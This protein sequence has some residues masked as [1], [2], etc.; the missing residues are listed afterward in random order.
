MRATRRAELVTAVADAQRAVRL[1]G[2]AAALGV[3]ALAFDAVT[4]PHFIKVSWVL[5]AAMSVCG[6]V[7]L[8]L[9]T[10]RRPTPKAATIGFLIVNA[11]ILV[12]L[13]VGTELIAESGVRWVPFRQYQL[14]AMVVALL[15]PPK[16]W[17]GVVTISAYAGAAL[18]QL[19]LFDPSIREHLPY[20]DP[21]ATVVYGV[22]AIAVLAY[23]LRSTRIEREAVRAHAEAQDYA[24]LARAMVALR[25][26][27]NSPLQTISN[28]VELLR[29]EGLHELADRLE[30]S[31]QKL[32]E[33]EEIT[34][35]YQRRLI[36]EA[37]DEA[38]N[39][40][41]VLRSIADRTAS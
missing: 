7:W 14:A 17:V 18:L 23:R 8:W 29:I 12:Q 1:T 20:G 25:D 34:R 24:L 41:V 28:I 4:S 33:I 27:S 15:A 31:V 36:W 19:A 37:G 9:I 30:R 22:L 3:F 10:S 38:W 5:W 39:P 13:W 21:W 6:A 2:V 32:V 11:A 26:L 16:A 35:P 40:K